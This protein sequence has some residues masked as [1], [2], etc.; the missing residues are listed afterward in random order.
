MDRPADIICFAKD[1]NEPKT[2]NHHVMEELAKRHRVL[3]VNSITT[4]APNL[5]SSN[6]LRKIARKIRSW[7]R[8]TKVIHD[9]LRVLTPVVLPFP[10]SRSAQAINRRLVCSMVRAAARRWRFSKPQLW[11]FL[12]NA[13]DYVGQF[14]ESKVVYYC[15]DEWSEFSNLDARFIQ[16]KEAELLQKAN[17]VFVVSQKLLAT[18]GKFHSNIHLVPHGVDHSLFAKALGAEFLP[19]EE[20]RM[21]PRPVVG[22]YGSLYDWVDQDLLCAI[23]RLRPAWSIVLVGK[24]MTDISPLRQH[25]N[26][27]VLGPR[28]HGELP[29][30]CKGFDVGIIPYRM[31]DRRMQSV[32]PLK[33]R[34]YLAAGLPVVSVDLP[35]ARGVAEDILIADTPE[36][37]V[38]RIE[39][40]LTRNSPARQRQR[41]DQ[42]QS[43]SW[44]A[45]VSV[46]ESILAEAEHAP[47]LAGGVR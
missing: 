31:Q 17:V 4:R 28:P 8:G 47:A 24:I 40:A 18:K 15:V 13:A 6:D 30:Y 12:P 27:H 2:S 5:A 39:Q 23:A 38:A 41:S 34:E 10:R 9:N 26:I 25:P 43:E 29:R 44:A 7:F 37:F 46:I 33:L 14:G 19:A 35:E 36:E 21:L 32:N 1:W 3:W 45:R 42:M 22:F 20:L 11:I 16:Q